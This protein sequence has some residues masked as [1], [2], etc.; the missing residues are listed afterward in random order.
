M[1]NE[2]IISQVTIGTE[3]LL[4]LSHMNIKLP[5][6]WNVLYEGIFTKMYNLHAE[7]KMHF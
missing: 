4:L 6:L 3:Y 7:K 5:T 2:F 1:G